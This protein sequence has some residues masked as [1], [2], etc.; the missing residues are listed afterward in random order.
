MARVKAVAEATL[1]KKEGKGSKRSEEE[2]IAALSCRKDLSSVV[3]K[4]F[5]AQTFPARGS[6]CGTVVFAL[7]IAVTTVVREA[8]Q[9]SSRSQRDI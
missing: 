8:P 4:T 7:F 6:F 2:Y 3:G 1:C 9:H 5:P